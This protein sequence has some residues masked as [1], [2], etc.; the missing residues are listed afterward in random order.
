MLNKGDKILIL[1]DEILK[2]TNSTDKHA[3]SVALVKKFTL[4]NCLVFIAT[5]DLSLGS[6]SDEFPQAVANCHF[7]SYIR[8]NELK[9]DY[10]LQKGIAQ[11]MNA[12]FL[13]QK[14]GIIDQTS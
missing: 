10:R 6:L 7:E 8:G 9:F 1:L 14:M 4:S 2:G 3:G 5:H 12:S 11:N 13:L